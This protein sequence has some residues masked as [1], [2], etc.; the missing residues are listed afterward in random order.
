MDAD[1]FATF[2]D[3]VM[4]YDN[5]DWEWKSNLLPLLPFE[6]WRDWLDRRAMY[7]TDK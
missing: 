6:D 5:P 3:D 1:E 7:A 4:N 2:I